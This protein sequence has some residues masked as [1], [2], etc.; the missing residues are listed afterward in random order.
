MDR[1]Y[2]WCHNEVERAPPEAYMKRTLTV[3]AAG[4]LAASVLV[5]ITTPAE[6]GPRTAP[7][8]DPVSHATGVDT[9]AEQDA[10]RA[11]W[12]S[13]RMRAAVPRGP[14]RP[15]AKPGGGGGPK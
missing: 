1:R 11:F 12:T 15:L 2:P 6:A 13:E 7:G 5:A 14:E 3:T 8:H 10:V 9:P 4:M